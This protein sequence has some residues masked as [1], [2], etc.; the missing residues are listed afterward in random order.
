LIEVLTR[1]RKSEFRTENRAWIGTPFT[2]WRTKSD[3]LHHA[4]DEG[5]EGLRER[6]REDGGVGA[7]LVRVK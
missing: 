2:F 3:D 4:I 7:V 5:A 1:A 6:R